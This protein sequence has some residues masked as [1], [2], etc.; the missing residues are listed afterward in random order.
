[1]DVHGAVEPLRAA[2]A[3]ARRAGRTIGL[4]PTM[5]ALHEGHLSL[6]RAARAGT[7]VVVA[8]I[9]VNPLQFAPGEDYASYPRDLDGDLARL[10]AQGVDA[11]LAPE[12]DELT[13]PER[14]TTV[15]VAGLTD[16]LEGV[17]RPGHFDGVTTIVA[18]LLNAVRPD[19]AYFGE[20][21]YQQLVVVRR[22]VSDLDFGVEV[23]GCPTVRDPDG[24][25]LS[26]RNAYLSA[27]ERAQARALSRAL[28]AV[29]DAWDGDATTARALLHRTLERAPGVHLD[30][31]E[32]ADPVTLE[33]L[34][35]VVDG[36]AQALVAARVGPARLI[37]N[38]RLDLR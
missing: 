21:D 24:L 3:P 29:R 28:F 17:H 25:A 33:P 14:A 2:L 7:E 6:A 4:V 22:M 32:V 15:H 5:G 34:G 1:M 20:K 35:G 10:D 16:R 18:T 23:I 30:Y 27:T 37:D 13:P 9:F 11:V 12:A 8:S 31:A 38:V 19:R 36:P 26:S